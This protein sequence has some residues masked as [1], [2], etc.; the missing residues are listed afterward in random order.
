MPRKNLKTKIPKKSAPQPCS[1]RAFSSKAA[2]QKEIER[3]SDEDIALHYYMC[4]NCG[5]V[6]LTSTI[7]A[8]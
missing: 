6:H 5:K 7:S 4:S 2:A 8:N 3:R 1:K